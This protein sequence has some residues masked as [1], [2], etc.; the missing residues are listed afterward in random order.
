MAKETKKRGS[1]SSCGADCFLECAG[2]FAVLMHTGQEHGC[3]E[4]CSETMQLCEECEE[5]MEKT[6]P[7]EVIA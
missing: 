6:N 4:D 2:C 3:P 7:E 5:G 1:C